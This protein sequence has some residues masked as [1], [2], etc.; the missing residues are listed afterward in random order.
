MLV[1]FE[2]GKMETYMGP[3]DAGSR[4]GPVLCVENDRVGGIAVVGVVGGWDRAVLIVCERV[5]KKV[6]S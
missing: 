5:T 6:E 3:N 1:N 4:L 2:N